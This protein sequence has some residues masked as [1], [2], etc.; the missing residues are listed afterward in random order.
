MAV[1]QLVPRILEQ[2]L[3]DSFA[4]VLTGTDRLVRFTYTRFNFASL[5]QPLELGSTSIKVEIIRDNAVIVT[6]TSMQ[7]ATNILGV[8]RKTVQRYLNHIKSFNS[9]LCGVVNIKEVHYAGPLLTHTLV[10]RADAQYEPLLIPGYEPDT[11]KKGPIYAFTKDYLL[12]SGGP[13][14]S[15][16]NAALNLHKS[17]GTAR[18]LRNS[19]SRALNYNHLVD[20]NVG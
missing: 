16:R 14:P 7:E 6:A 1:T 4:S 20:T 11:L 3:F 18:G 15:M 17:D 12:Y 19:I 9:P 5:N 2:S 13:Y 8:G 10:H